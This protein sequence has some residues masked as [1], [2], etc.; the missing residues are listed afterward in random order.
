MSDFK[1]FE[2]LLK[3]YRDLQLRVTQFSA[4]EQKLINTQDRL[5]YELLL[6]KRLQKFNSLALQDLSRDKF[7][8]LISESIIDIL[9]VES[10]VVCFKNLIDVKDSLFF[11]EGIKYD[12]INQLDFI[13]DIEILLNNNS[14][15]N[16]LLLKSNEFLKFKSLQNI[17]EG[18]LFYFHEKELGYSFW[19]FGFVSLKNKNLYQELQPRHETVFSLFSQQVQSLFAN[20]VKTDKINKQIEQIIA[21]EIELKKLSLIATKTKNG[22][23]ISDKEGRIEWVNDAF[24][25]T[26]GYR[27]DEVFLK[28]PKDLL[29]GI[30]SDKNEIKKIS[31]AIKAKKNIESTI[32]NYNKNGQEYYNQIEITPILNEAG[33]LMNFVSLQKDITEEL[34][35]QK[36]ILRINSKFELI[37]SKS[38][39]GIWEWETATNKVVWNDIIIAQYGLK[40]ENS[41]ELNFIDIW[42]QS[43]HPDDKERVLY[44]TNH[45]MNSDDEIL[46]Q[47]YKI[48]RNDDQQVRIVKDI[49]IAERDEKGVLLRLIGSTIDI[50]QEKENKLELEYNLKQQELL[51]ELSLGLNNLTDFGLRINNAIDKIG[52]Y[53]NISRV[54][55]YE[56]SENSTVCS[57]TYEWCRKDINSQIEESRDIIYSD[58]PSLKQLLTQKGV[59]CVEDISDLPKDLVDILK[60]KDVKS[61]IIYPIYIKD[62]F[63]GFI[64]F[65]ECIIRKKWLKSEIEL[66]RIVSGIISNAYERYH[67]EKSLI[68]SEEKYRNIIEN[69]N[70][71]LVESNVKGE[72]VFNNKKFKELT[73][74]DIPALMIL[75]NDPEN[76]LKQK[77]LKKIIL[78]YT[79]ID[80]SVYEIEFIRSDKKLITLLISCAPTINQQGEISGYINAFW[81]ITS[82]K[83]LQKKLETALIERDSFIQKT[84]SLKLFYESI[85][86]HSPAQIAVISDD[87]SIRY[88]NEL[89]IQEEPYLEN[90]IGKTISEIALKYTRQ[91]QRFVKLNKHIFE[92]VNFKKLI[93]VEEFLVDKLT[94]KPKVILRSILPYY[95][96]QDKLE[97][98]ILTGVDITD[99]KNIETAILKKNDELKK[100]NTELDNFVYSV[101]HDLRSPLLSIKGI[102]DLISKTSVLDDKTSNY[103]KLA[104]TSAVRLDGTIQEILEYSKNSR[105][106]IEL[107]E[108]N[109]EE[110]VQLIFDDLKYSDNNKVLFSIE[111]E[112]SPVITTD[113]SRLNTLLKNLIGNSVKYK[114]KDIENSFVKFTLHR[115]DDNILIKVIDNGIGIS[116]KSIDKVFD[117]FYRGTKSSVGTGLGLY[118]CKEIINKLNGTIS[119]QSVLN[120]GTTI[121]ISIPKLSL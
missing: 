69:I 83:T 34:Q 15:G 73:L 48:I 105:F 119:V 79:K 35:Y 27:L 20:K 75:K 54:Y 51:S 57:N 115:K 120:E 91:D 29:Q 114:R 102:L 110:M 24:T 18:L 3:E 92:A 72:I 16:T 74:L 41:K 60:P 84:N 22:V 65:E 97:Y 42:K 76:E 6:Y 58:I 12:K 66:L 43:I 98:V 49:T 59:I 47:E 31:E 9:E 94:N 81:D 113:K 11:S 116:E 99:L 71:G 121:Y 2:D 100:I 82:V 21:S 7:I 104:E 96:E 52:T 19:I 112:G 40:N 46:E 88:I 93:Q 10:S 64:G 38:H 28:K 78:S 36:E 26:S 32:I 61:I 37:T 87:F 77:V 62:V 90:A 63:F 17:S 111:I 103:L 50:T 80:N 107:S 55:I 25:K 13:N 5:D 86:N 70:I 33:E 56:D 95:N 68:A 106:D 101:S 89:M 8:R 44:N 23:I 45:I 4:I 67:A 53:S 117:M 1:D 14:S 108:F 30:N 118:I 109:V 85:L 39:I